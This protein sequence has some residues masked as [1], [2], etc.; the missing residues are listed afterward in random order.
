MGTDRQGRVS[1]C[2]YPYIS[3][4][5]GSGSPFPASVAISIHGHRQSGC[6]AAPNGFRLLYRGSHVV[7][8]QGR[9]RIPHGPG[10]AVCRSFHCAAGGVRHRGP[11]AAPRKWCSTTESEVVRLTV[12]GPPRHNR[13]GRPLRLRRCWMTPWRPSWPRPGCPG[14]GIP[15]AWTSPE[16][17]DRR[18]LV[19]IQAKTPTRGR[20]PEPHP[21]V[22]GNHP[23]NATFLSSV[24][25][26]WQTGSVLS[27][28]YVGSPEHRLYEPR[29][30]HPRNLIKI[31]F[32]NCLD[33]TL[34][35]P[36]ARFTVPS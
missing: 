30:R 31:L 20:G 29:S 14:S 10:G 35:S 16:R 18:G 11:P 25:N 6:K 33:H 17:A 9:R 21:A 13:R 34:L 8:R 1:F 24:V 26:G 2:L 22:G 19:D 28:G 32:R 23:S 27:P 4:A 12:A 15:G 7:A 5:V 3:C 36:A